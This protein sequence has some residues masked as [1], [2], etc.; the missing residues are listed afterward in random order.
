MLQK[1]EIASEK[2]IQT[3]CNKRICRPAVG[4]SS[5]I[6]LSYASESSKLTSNFLHGMFF[7]AVL[8]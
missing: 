5:D 8:V 2:T 1:W 3:A 6:N 4:C 7:N